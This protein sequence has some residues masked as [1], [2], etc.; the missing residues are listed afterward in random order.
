MGTVDYHSVLAEPGTAKP[1][2]RFTI[3]DSV[4]LTWDIS[5]GL[6]RSFRDCDLLY[7]EPAWEHGFDRY[8]ERS[9]E[10]IEYADYIGAI[11]EIMRTDDRPAVLIVG[12][13]AAR[14][15]PEPSSATPLHLNSGG[16]FIVEAVALAYRCI[17]PRVTARHR[18]W[19]NIDSANL[20]HALA[21]QYSRVG[22]FSCG[23][24]NTGRIFAEHRCSWVMSDSSAECIGH[25]AVH[26]KAW[27][28]R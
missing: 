10:S 21:K 11:S 13:R 17:L 20:L 18:G 9:G 6:H 22:D 16:R 23:Y 3:G 7:S 14:A 26:A 25:I 19:T 24:G 28:P 1:R 5:R 12:K 2:R 27:G 15:L 8:V 4:A